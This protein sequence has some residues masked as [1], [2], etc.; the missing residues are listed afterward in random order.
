MTDHLIHPQELTSFLDGNPRAVLIDVRGMGKGLEFFVDGHIKN[1]IFFDLEEDLSDVNL[2]PEIGGRHPLPSLENFYKTLAKKGIEAHQDIV[3]YDNASGALGAARLWWMLKAIGH[4]CVRLLDGGLQKSVDLG[5]E[6]VQGLPSYHPIRSYGNTVANW[7]LPVVSFEEVQLKT[8]ESNITLIDVRGAN[9]F[10]GIEEPI[11]PYAGH[12]PSATN[13]PFQHHFNSDGTF[14][15]LEELKSL[16]ENL[17][18]NP[19][20]FYC[21]SGVSACHSIFVFSMIGKLIP[22]LFV[23]SWSLWCRKVLS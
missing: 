21:G 17:E 6:I 4:R 11:D 14:K 23:G 15:S 16:Y 7:L 10:A 3:I 13:R 1:A 19:T 5:L 18:E 9:R 20:I 22:A 2:G 8:V 12:I